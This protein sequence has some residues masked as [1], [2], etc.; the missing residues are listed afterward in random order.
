MERS[1]HPYMAWK[2]CIANQK[3][4]VGKT[5]SAVNLAASLAVLGRRCLLIDLDPQGNA[6]SGL[7]LDKSTLRRS[8]YHVLVEDDPL[9]SVILPTAVPHLSLAPANIDL[10]GAELEMVPLENRERLLAQRLA[11]TP[12][13]YEFVL[14]DCPPSLGLLTVNALAAADS[15]LVPVQCEYYALEGLSQ[16]LNTVTLVKRRLNPHLKIE[17]FLLTMFDI[18]NRICSQVADEVRGHFQER[19]FQTL[20]ARNVRLSEAPSHG[21]PALLYDPAS[22]GAQA[23]LEAARELLVRHAARAEDAAPERKV[24]AGNVHAGKVDEGRVKEGER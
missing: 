23:Y 9:G 13:E 2:I 17:G 22:R 8:I 1:S 4:G 21:Q 24:H 12:A 14:I 20:V 10:S 7:G 16:L 15:V 5:T 18:R 6:T 19:V 11:A 3:G